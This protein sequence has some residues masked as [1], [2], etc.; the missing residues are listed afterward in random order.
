MVLIIR[1][2][3]DAAAASINCDKSLICHYPRLAGYMNKKSGIVALIK[4]WFLLVFNINV[5]SLHR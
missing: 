4:K 5:I 3:Q 1:V 2:L